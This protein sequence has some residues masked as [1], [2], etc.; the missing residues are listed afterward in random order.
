MADDL[1]KKAAKAAAKV[2]PHAEVEDYDKILKRVRDDARR[3]CNEIL[4]VDVTPAKWEPT[5]PAPL[6][7]PIVKAIVNNMQVFYKPTMADVLTVVERSGTEH[8]IGSLGEFGVLIRE[9]GEEAFVGTPQSEIVD[10]A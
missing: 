5:E 2:D 9:L 4:T 10:D 1:F 3:T 7:F 6:E 8:V